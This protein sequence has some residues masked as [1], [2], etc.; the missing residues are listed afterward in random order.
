MVPARPRILTGE[1]APPERLLPLPHRL[2]RLLGGIALVAALGAA[3][4]V[5][6]VHGLVLLLR[7]LG[8]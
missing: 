1:P 3:A 2:A 6:L 7:Q 4:F 5:G 8:P